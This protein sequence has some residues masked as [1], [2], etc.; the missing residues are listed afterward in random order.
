MAS[1]FCVCCLCVNTV[2]IPPLFF[3][4]LI[5]TG[6]VRGKGSSL[7]SRFCFR[8]PLQSPRNVLRALCTVVKSLCCPQ[9]LCLVFKRTCIVCNTPA[10]SAS[11][12][13]LSTGVLQRPQ[14]SCTDLRTSALTPALSSGLLHCPQ[15]PNYAVLRTNS[16]PTE[17]FAVR[18]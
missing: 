17:S 4:P 3:T 18:Y 9:D 10:L 12:I 6:A 2:Y 1:P 7:K 13:A 11:R 15:P 8:E 16:Q 14:E 5:L